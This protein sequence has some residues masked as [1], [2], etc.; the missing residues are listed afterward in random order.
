FTAT[1]IHNELIAVLERGYVSYNTVVRWIQQLSDE[2]DTLED[3]PRSDRPKTAVIQRNVDTFKNT[4]NNDPHIST[5]YIRSCHL[6][7]IP[8]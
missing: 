1:Q 8:W 3:N 6:R 2:E 7:Y 5:D 4:V